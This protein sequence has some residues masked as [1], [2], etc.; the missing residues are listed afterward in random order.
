MEHK[1]EIPIFLCYLQVVMAELR[2][3]FLINE[4]E[5]FKEIRVL[6]SCVYN[7]LVSSIN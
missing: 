7:T 2:H 1:K 3:M 4:S 6:I 5:E